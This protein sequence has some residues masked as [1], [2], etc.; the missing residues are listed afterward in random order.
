MCEVKVVDSLSVAFNQN[1]KDPASL[2]P[3]SAEWFSLMRIGKLILLFKC[4]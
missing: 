2:K 1:G 3:I 4:I